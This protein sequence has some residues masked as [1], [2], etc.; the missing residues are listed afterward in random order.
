M[1]YRDNVFLTVAP[2]EVDE[3]VFQVSPSLNLDY[4]NQRV[5]TTIRY[6]FDWYDY[7]DLDATNEYHSYDAMFTGQLVP[8][9]FFIE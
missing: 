5:S 1:D 6:Q 3:T 2:N 7:S 8:D 4:E 9:A